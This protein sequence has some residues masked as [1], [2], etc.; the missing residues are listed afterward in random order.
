MPSPLSLRFSS[1]WLANRTDL[2]RHVHVDVDVADAG[3]VVGTVRGG[4]LDA[5]D[6]DLGPDRTG[7]RFV[8]GLLLEICSPPLDGL[9]DPRRA[10][11][12]RRP[13]PAKT[14]PT[15]FPRGGAQGVIRVLD[16]LHLPALRGLEPLAPGVGCRRP[17]RCVT[18][19]ETSESHLWLTGGEL[20]LSTGFAVRSGSLTLQTWLAGLAER[21]IAALAIADRYVDA[22]DRASMCQWAVTCDTAVLSVPA[23]CAW[24]DI[25]GPV[26]LQLGRIPDT[27]PSAEDDRDL[28]VLTWLEGYGPPPESAR[29]CPQV[30]LSRVD[31][32][33]VVRA[34]ATAAMGSTVVL[35]LRRLL[36]ARL[37]QAFPGAVV[38]R[39][40]DD[41]PVLVRGGK[42]SRMD[43]V[44]S[45][46]RLLLGLI[47]QFPGLVL[48]AGV[49]R[50]A[51]GAAELHTSY[52]QARRALE[53]S[54]LF[55]SARVLHYD[56]LGILRLLRGAAS[57]PQL[58]EFYH[59]TL[60]VLAA[61]EHEA[62]RQ[63]LAAYFASDCSLVACG[64]SLFLH[65]HTVRYRLDRVQA[66]TGLSLG[67]ADDRL[68]LQCAL[69]IGQ[70]LAPGPVGSL[71]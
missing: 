39:A 63:T 26:C 19:D 13:R 34:D 23:Q 21:Q 45:V 3:E 14:S 2:R 59:E 44:T 64:R 6:G 37:S 27:V 69:K 29:R 61:D 52:G 65:P 35:H 5:A 20:V 55:D 66:L 25:I 4:V 30:D 43:V 7:R 57:R 71:G 41:F 70:W 18:V 48:R 8:H 10:A 40:G 22:L 50:V 33:V 11:E 16:L 62:L 32:A 51:H 15:T 49:G 54:D 58:M 56:D 31:T 68:A 53:F 28:F 38:V 67:L 47:E 12:D 42:S 46:D 9:D 1:C 36:T 17:V 24:A 60:K